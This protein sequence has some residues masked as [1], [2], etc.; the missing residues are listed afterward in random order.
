MTLQ[1]RDRQL[2]RGL[3][4]LFC[5]SMLLGV[6]HAYAETASAADGASADTGL[7]EVMVFA[8][9]R[10]ENVQTVPTPVTVISAQEIERQ[11]LANFTNFQY[12][13]PAF[14]VYLTNPKQQNL[15]IR[16]IGNNGFNTDG[17]D[18]SVGI[19]V[20]GVYTGRQGMVSGDFS[21][22][23][24]TSSCCAARRARCLA[25]TPRPAR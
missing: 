8:R 10:S 19:F 3:A 13:F 4:L 15:G 5:S 1:K 17:I 7:E 2:K 21:D 24:P 16:G 18:G 6:S 14:S 22:L 11:H 25:R 23:S 9:K 12:K 20:D